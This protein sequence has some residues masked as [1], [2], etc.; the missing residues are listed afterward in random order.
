MLRVALTGVN[1]MIGRHMRALLEHRGYEVIGIDRAVWDLTIWKS[2]SELD[3]MLDGVAV[4]FHFAAALPST[5]STDD[6]FNNTES[7]VIFDVNVRS[8]LNLSEWA[9]IRNVPIVFLSGATVYKDPHARHITEVSPEVVSGLGGLYG[10][11]KLLA[12]KTIL[13][14][15]N[16]GLDA[17]ILRPSSVYGDGLAD[18][19]LVTSYLRTAVENNEITITEPDNRINMIHAADVA[20]AA[21]IG[22]EMKAW[23]VFNVASKATTS[24]R[25]LAETAV[26]TVGSGKIRIA[27]IDTPSVPFV[28]F[29]LNCSEAMNVFGFESKINI[30]DGLK[31]MYGKKLLLC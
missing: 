9:L 13:N 20:E 4:V 30:K 24:I 14:F 23:G 31:L 3:C 27:A 21:L 7:R 6:I 25:E 1:G 15:V 12:E 26:E 8:C 18:D 16:Q 29:D 11:S 28:R 19:K 5:K 17:L 10:Y 2:V 22:Y